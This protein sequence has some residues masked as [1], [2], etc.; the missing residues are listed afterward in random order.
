MFEPSL[1]SPSSAQTGELKTQGSL[2]HQLSSKGSFLRRCRLSAFLILPS[3]LLLRLSSIWSHL[4]GKDS[5]LLPSSHWKERDSLPLGMTPLKISSVQSCP[6]LC[7]PMDCSTPAL[8]VH[9][10]LLELT[11]TQIHWVSDATQP[12]HPLSSPSPPAFN[13]SQ[14]QGLFQGASSSHQMAKVFQ[15][16]PQDQSFQRIFR[17]DYL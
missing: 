10:Q 12:S 2:S 16:Q 8:P 6:T 17:T 3:Y 5:F 1:F 14:H 15:F 13:L 7:D 11:Q 4:I 9:H